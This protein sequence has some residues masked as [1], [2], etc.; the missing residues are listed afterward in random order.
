MGERIVVRGALPV[1]ISQILKFPGLQKG[2]IVAFWIRVLSIQAKAALSLLM[3]STRNRYCPYSYSHRNFGG[4]TGYAG[5]PGNGGLRY[6]R[7]CSPG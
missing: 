2:I 7:M 4:G 6:V 5:A 1:P 3:Q